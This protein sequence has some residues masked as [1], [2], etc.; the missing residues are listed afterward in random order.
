MCGSRVFCTLPIIGMNIGFDIHARKVL[1][2]CDCLL[3]FAGATKLHA[4]RETGFSGFSKKKQ[5]AAYAWDFD[6][7]SAVMNFLA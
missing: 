2:S 3:H 4:C 7:L 5:L 6:L 1:D